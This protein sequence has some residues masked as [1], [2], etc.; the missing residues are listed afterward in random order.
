MEKKEMKVSSEAKY[1]SKSSKVSGRR[2][3][4]GCG[5]GKKRR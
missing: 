5:C 3:K 4:K 2:R 1:V